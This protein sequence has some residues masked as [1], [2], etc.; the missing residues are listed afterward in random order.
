MK[1]RKDDQVVIIK[2]KDKGKKGKVLRGFPDISKVLIEAVNIRKKHRRAKKSNEKGQ[3][4]EAPTP[5]SV[6]KL[7]L[8]CPKCA[9]P[10]KIGYKVVEKNRFR[11]CKKCGEEI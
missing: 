3:V 11:V 7:K 8:L 2:G 1:I 6:F 9:K 5:I 10:T 4:V